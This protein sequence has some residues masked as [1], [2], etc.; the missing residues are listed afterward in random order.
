[1][2]AEGRGRRWTEV[3]CIPVMQRVCVLNT[4]CSRWEFDDGEGN[5]FSWTVAGPTMEVRKYVQQ[6][7]DVADA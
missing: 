2:V 3:L 4:M 5:Y 7:A 6:V 1:M